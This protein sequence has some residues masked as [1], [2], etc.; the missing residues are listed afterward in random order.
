MC[1]DD[2]LNMNARRSQVFARIDERKHWLVCSFFH[3]NRHHHSLVCSIVTAFDLICAKLA[4]C[5]NADCSS[6]YRYLQVEMPCM[7]MLLWR[8]FTS[9]ILSLYEY[10]VSQ[11]WV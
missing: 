9:Q 10:Q 1:G 11:I 2:K 6:G 7:G 8:S 4:P 3:I 5:Y